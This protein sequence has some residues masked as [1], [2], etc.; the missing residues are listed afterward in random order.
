MGR[1]AIRSV[2]AVGRSCTFASARASE[3]AL[4]Q[5]DPQW[6]SR[7]ADVCSSP[8]NAHI[9]RVADAG[10][11]RNGL[12]V[13][14]NGIRVG[15]LSYTGAGALQMLVANRG[16]HEPQEERAFG[17]ILRCISPGGIMLELGAFWAFYSL[18]F[19]KDVAEAKCYIVE[20]NASSLAAGR[21][22]FRLNNRSAVFEQAYI[23]SPEMRSDDGVP[24]VTVQDFCRRHGVKHLAI[25][26]ADIQ[27]AELEMLQG[28]QPML[29]S[30]SVDYLF[31]STHSDDLH[32]RCLSELGRHGYA[33]LA[34]ADL[35]QTYS[36]DGLIVAKSPTAEG[37]DTLEISHKVTGGDADA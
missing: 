6:E 36:T 34:S 18:W 12:V 9:P 8:D 16:V 31:I 4:R 2:L 7:I 26:H 19:L 17:E 23:G 10:E 32:Y 5:R 24:Y 35:K 3:R 13:M 22:N 33:I 14:H 37:P 27:F 20:P 21:V 15:A 1:R 30:R 28:M 25:L 29:E 11:V